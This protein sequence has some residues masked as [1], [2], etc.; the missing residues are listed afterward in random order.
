MFNPNLACGIRNRV[1]LRLYLVP[2]GKSASL[3]NPCKI[4]DFVGGFT[5]AP[6]YHR[7]NFTDTEKRFFRYN[8][9]YALACIH[10]GIAKADKEKSSNSQ[11]QEPIFPQLAVI[12]ANKIT[13]GGINK[14]IILYLRC[15]RRMK[16]IVAAAKA[17]KLITIQSAFACNLTIQ[18][19]A[20][21]LF[22]MPKDENQVNVTSI[23]AIIS[24][25]YSQSRLAVCLIMWIKTKRAIGI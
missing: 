17:T 22:P 7:V 4:F 11:P 25:A 8:Y 14:L 18:S 10:S 21:S 12:T 13:S 23:G 2:C 9:W 20:K 24:D 6:E 3:P 15:L 16:A 1:N 19:F 5:R